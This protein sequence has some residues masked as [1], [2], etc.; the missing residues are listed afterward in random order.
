MMMSEG[1]PQNRGALICELNLV[2]SLEHAGPLVAVFSRDLVTVTLREL[3]VSAS[4]IKALLYPLGLGTVLSSLCVVRHQ[5]GPKDTVVYSRFLVES[6][7]L[8]PQ[9]AKSDLERWPQSQSD[10]W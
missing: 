6:V 1:E 10:P 3:T 4:E 2:N 5:D 7:F 9:T 8:L